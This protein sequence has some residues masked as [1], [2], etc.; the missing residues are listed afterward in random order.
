MQPSDVWEYDY[1][2][3]APKGNIYNCVV[4][5]YRKIESL[6]N[7][8]EAPTLQQIDYQALAKAVADELQER[9]KN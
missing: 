9:L 8:I 5:M 3:T 6:E 2:G 4:E 7:A 1:A